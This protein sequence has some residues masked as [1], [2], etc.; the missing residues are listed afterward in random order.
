MNWLQRQ[1]F[2]FLVFIGSIFPDNNKSIDLGS[3]YVIRD[4]KCIVPTN[5]YT[6]T[7]IYS[8]VIDYKFNDKFIIAKQTPKI[9]SYKKLVREDL[10]TRLIIYDGFLKERN[11]KDYEKITTP[12]IVNSIKS[13]SLIYYRFKKNGLKENYYD[14]NL[15]I[16]EVVDSI[17]KNDMFYKKILRNKINYW[18]INK[19]DNTRF[20]PFTRIEFENELK[21]KNINLQFE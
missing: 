7:E 11:D 18:I 12:S 9:S 17:L 1:L 6:D 5:L 15:K 4:N 14:K 13:D 10:R 3:D 2:S 21:I 19:L 8:K 16:E 20:G